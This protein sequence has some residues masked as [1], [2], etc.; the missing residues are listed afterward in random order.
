MDGRPL[1]QPAAFIHERI[2]HGYRREWS[3]TLPGLAS[4]AAN[5]GSQSMVAMSRMQGA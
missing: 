2:R 4:D 5:F 1:D 3:A